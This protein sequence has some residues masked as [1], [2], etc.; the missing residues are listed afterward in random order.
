MREIV[1]IQC[2]L[3]ITAALYTSVIKF[4]THSLVRFVQGGAVWQPDRC[5]VLG[6]AP[7]LRVLETA[8]KTYFFCALICILN[9]VNLYRQ[10]LRSDAE[11]CADI[12]GNL[13]RTWRGCERL[14]RRGV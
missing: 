13:R 12:A 1:A 8:F 11:C 3:P 10:I 6:G 5:Q 9:V 4:V 14:V 2:V 7:T